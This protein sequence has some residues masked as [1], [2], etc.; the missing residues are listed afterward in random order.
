M[1]P[2]DHAGNP[3][4]AE[5]KREWPYEENEDSCQHDHQQAGGEGNTWRCGKDRHGRVDRHTEQEYD[6]EGTEDRQGAFDGYHQARAPDQLKEAIFQRLRYIM[7]LW[8]DAQSTHTRPP[9]FLSS[10]SA[11]TTTTINVSQIQESQI[12]RRVSSV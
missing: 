2:L 12:V 9:R 5:A 11:V 10:H 3:R 8:T 7:K 4:Q 1:P 6:D